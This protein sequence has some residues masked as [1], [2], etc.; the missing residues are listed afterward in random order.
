MSH[1]YN[2]LGLKPINK[3]I[4]LKNFKKVLGVTEISNYN[5]LLNLF[6]ESNLNYKTFNHSNT[7]IKIKK[8]KKK[9]HLNGNTYK[10]VVK[11]KNKYKYKSIFIKESPILNLQLLNI[12]LIDLF[13]KRYNHKK[14]ITMEYM[15]SLNSPANIELFCCYITSKLFERKISPHFSLFYGF[16]YVEM[17]KFTYEISNEWIDLNRNFIKNKNIRI[18]NKSNRYYLEKQHLPCLLIYLENL[19]LDLND[20][21]DNSLSVPENEWTAYIFQ[22]ICALSCIQKFYNL[23]HNDLH[24]S[25]I[26]YNYTPN[27]YIYY[28]YKSIY[29]RIPTYNKIIKIID[30]GRAS[31]NF[32]NFRSKNLCFSVK[33][34]AFGQY[35][36]NRIN[37]KG[38]YTS[39]NNPSIDL[40]I[41]SKNLMN[42]DKFP[43]KGRLFN[44]INKWI[45]YEHDAHKEM[46]FDDYIMGVKNAYRSI[47]IE[48]LKSSIFKKYSSCKK[49]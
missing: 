15:N 24:L 36:Y 45:N 20:Y 21:I 23:C 35:F 5:C 47:P 32:N 3:Q 42:L 30:W 6:S 12:D 1:I 27:K 28:K 48:Q 38:K 29:F 10:G 7:L 25:N 11:Y 46:T 13:D 34:D 31:Y 18:F 44:L 41:L 2:T 40:Y 8:K 17:K 9:I 37:N 33:G 19:K 22:V 43:K 16:N 26:M 4:K 14:G 49:N 39:D